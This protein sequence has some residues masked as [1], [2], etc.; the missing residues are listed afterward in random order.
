MRYLLYLSLLSL[1]SCDFA[2]KN[3]TKTK[4]Q[5]YEDDAGFSRKLNLID[6]K[7]SPDGLYAGQGF[8]SIVGK[9]MDGIIVDTPL[10]PILYNTAEGFGQTVYL[11]VKLINSYEELRQSLSVDIAASLQMG[12]FKGSSEMKMLN[13]HSFNSFSTFLLMN[14]QVQNPSVGIKPQNYKLTE[15]ALKLINNPDNFIRSFGNQ[16]VSSIETGGSLYVLFEY[17]STDSKEKNELSLKLS[18][19]VKQLFGR[20]SLNAE[21]KNTLEHIEWSNSLS[22]TFAG[23]GVCGR[24]PALNK[25]SLIDYMRDFPDMVSP[26][27]C[28][29]ITGYSFSSNSILAE[30][31]NK[32]MFDTFI[33]QK[34]FIEDCSFKNDSLTTVLGNI[35]YAQK[36]PDEFEN[37]ELPKLQN[38]ESETVRQQRQLQRLVEDCSENINLCKATLND[39]IVPKLDLK[40]KAGNPK[41]QPMFFDKQID[42]LEFF[43]STLIDSVTLSG[44]KTF[45]LRGQFGVLKPVS[46]NESSYTYNDENNFAIEQNWGGLGLEKYQMYFLIYDSRTNS[47][48]DKIPY[49]NSPVKVERKNSYVKLQLVCSGLFSQEDMIATYR[50]PNF[51][52]LLINSKEKPLHVLIY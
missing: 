46:S 15:K 21:I 24:L 19:Q 8:N 1:L 23:T 11:N 13:D 17:K 40:W 9:K 36:Y 44:Y 26:K 49:T 5:Y 37:P 25:D 18:A 3:E 42:S 35:K 10:V 4:V 48:V 22:V 29:S 50:Q 43:A 27:K 6:N 47:L 16:F 38:L 12:A 20:A 51:K 41:N 7:L 28:P 52:P 45:E 39:I 30:I 33:R 31:P 2:K 14:L 32:D 34:H